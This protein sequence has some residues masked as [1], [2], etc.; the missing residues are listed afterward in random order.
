MDFFWGERIARALSAGEG[1]KGGVGGD[2]SFMIASSLLP[3]LFFGVFQ[4]ETFLA[5]LSGGSKF[6]TFRAAE[7]F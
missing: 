3:F 7:H 2:D 6:T 1:G 4:G 5:T